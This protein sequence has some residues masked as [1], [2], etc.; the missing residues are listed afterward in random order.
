M[1][2]KSS[3]KMKMKQN[4]G[5]KIYL[6]SLTKY[7]YDVVVVSGCLVPCLEQHKIVLLE[8]C[9]ILDQ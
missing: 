1:D 9:I 6:R 4:V 2:S 7:K 5:L 3:R 8:S